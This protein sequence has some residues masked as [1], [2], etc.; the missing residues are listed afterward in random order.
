MSDQENVR[1]VLEAAAG[2][3]KVASA[4]AAATIGLGSGAVLAQVQTAL[5]ITSLV[6]GCIVGLYV[7][8]INAVKL[9]IYQRML[10]NGESLKE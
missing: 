5:G 6:I 1:T 8:R 3:P 10:E 4:V 2:H 7:R 9:K